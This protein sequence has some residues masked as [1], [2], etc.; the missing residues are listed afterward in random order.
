MGGRLIMEIGEIIAK[1]FI[2]MGE[3]E[4]NKFMDES[5]ANGTL[6]AKFRDKINKLMDLYRLQSRIVKAAQAGDVDAVKDLR[7]ELEDF[8]EPLP[9]PSTGGV[10]KEEITYEVRYNQ[11]LRL[12][13]ETMLAELKGSG[14]KPN[15]IQDKRNELG[16]YKDISSEWLEAPSFIRNE[17]GK[18][19]LADGLQ[20]STSQLFSSLTRKQIEEIQNS[21]SRLR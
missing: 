11:A 12:L 17:E 19:S 9:E 20:K 3:R 6:D 13:A 7:G 4:A 5:E 15:E 1:N 2:K 8:I 14:A 18:Q 21:R 10:S 16:K